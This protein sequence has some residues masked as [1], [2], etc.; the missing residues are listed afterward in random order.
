MHKVKFQAVEG[1]F[2][3]S[4][5]VHIALCIVFECGGRRFIVIEAAGWVQSFS[6]SNGFHASVRVLVSVAS[7][8]VAIHVSGIAAGTV[9]AAASCAA[10][11]EQD[12]YDVTLSSC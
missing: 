7:G 8:S 2:Q 10:N 5:A 11:R 9:P 3:S 12:V 1:F 6:S 4:Q